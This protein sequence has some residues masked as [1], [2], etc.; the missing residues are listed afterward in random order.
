MRIGRDLKI[1]RC[2]LIGIILATLLLSI[3]GGVFASTIILIV[4]F[5]I[6]FFLVELLIASSSTRKA[7]WIA[8]GIILLI[9][10]TT[11]FDYK[12]N[13]P[14]I[15]LILIIISILMFIFDLP[16]REWLMKN[17]LPFRNN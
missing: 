16:I 13:S 5:V 10:F 6:F 9:L 8:Y 17:N 1:P 14:F 3:V 7:L 15:P 2:V 4:P 11:N 12:N